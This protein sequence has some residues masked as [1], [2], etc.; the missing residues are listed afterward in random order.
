MNWNAIDSKVLQTQLSP[1]WYEVSKGL[2]LVAAGYL[3]LITLALPGALLLGLI[4]HN[5]PLFHPRLVLGQQQKALL[6]LPVPVALCLVVLLGFGMVLA[7]KVRCLTHS[8]QHR[9]AKE[10]MLACITCF[11]AGLFLFVAAHFF[12]GLQNYLVF[13]KG[14]GALGQI[15]LLNAGTLFQLVGAALVLG[16]WLLF[17][18]FQRRIAQYFEDKAVAL[19]VDIYLFYVCLMIGGSIGVLA[20]P[21]LASRGEVFLALVGGWLVCVLAQV[22]LMVSTGRCIEEALRG[23]SRSEP[24]RPQTDAK[25]GTA[26]S[27]SGL[28]RTYKALFPSG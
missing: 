28:H 24:P 13:E 11:L 6:D 23:S 14:L 25:A 19:R 4:F 12:G 26:V 3:L 1:K 17:G 8:T 22:V 10:V 9:G 20:S 15:S 7:G 16:A 18:Q 21:R 27:R 5:G 2:T